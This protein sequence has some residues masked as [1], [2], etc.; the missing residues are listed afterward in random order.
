M[1][2][3]QLDIATE[4]NVVFVAGMHAYIYSMLFYMFA[5]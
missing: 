1:L 3:G 2:W 4:V 5:Y